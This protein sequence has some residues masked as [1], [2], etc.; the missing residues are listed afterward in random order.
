MRVLLTAGGTGGHVMPALAIADSLKK[1]SPDL[2]L[3]FVGTDRGLEERLTRARGMDFVPLRALG[4]KGKSIRDVVRSG[5]INLR[6]FLSALRIIRRFRPDW[7]IGTGGYVTGMVVLAGRLSGSLCAIQEQNSI[8]GLTNR[9]LSRIAH[10]VFLAYP[11][12]RGIFP[13]EKT[14]L[15]GNPVREELT[16]EKGLEHP[17]TL[18]VLGGS[19]GARSINRAAPEAL[20]MLKK[21]G[22]RPEVIHQCGSADYPWVSEA[23]RA[24]G[25]QAQVHEFIDDMAAVYRRASLAVCRSGGLTLSELSRMKV[26]GIMAPYPLATDDHQMKNAHFVASRGGGWIIPDQHLTAQ[27]LALEILTRI[28]DAEGLT[29]AARSM[30]RMNLGDGA[31]RIAREILNV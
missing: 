23:Y 20:V 28:S 12:T 1:L 6:A 11:D 5:A 16:P 7:I 27:R 15:T 17:P 22:L 13:A 18:L 29:E 10:R 9:I 21:Q 2:E 14:I 26:P 3:V 19:L 30:Y 25:I 4:V 24:G 8:P 31:P